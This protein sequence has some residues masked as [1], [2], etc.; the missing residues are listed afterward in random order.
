[1]YWVVVRWKS[2]MTSKTHVAFNET[3]SVVNE[4]CSA[5]RFLN[6]ATADGLMLFQTVSVVIGGIM[7][8]SS[9]QVFL[10]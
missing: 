3:V 6:D 9:K 1:M 5:D 10:R 7:G 8:I 4:S 2:Y